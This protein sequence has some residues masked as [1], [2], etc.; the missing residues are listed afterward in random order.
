MADTR[1]LAQLGASTSDTSRL[2]ARGVRTASDLMRSDLLDVAD[3]LR[4]SV[5]GASRALCRV[6]KAVA[7]SATDVA[8]M[9]RM[10]ASGHLP[11][12]I[13]PLDAAMRGGLPPRAITELA[14]PAGAG[15][16]QMCFAL[17]LSAA[18][19]TTY[20]GKERRA[21]YVDAE[22][23]FSAK[24]VAEMARAWTG[25]AMQDSDVQGTLARIRVVPPPEKVEDMAPLLLGLEQMMIQDRVAVVAVDSVAVLMR[26]DASRRFDL[27]GAQASALRHLAESFN[28]PVVVTNQVVGGGA[29]AGSHQPFG[30][31]ASEGGEAEVAAALGVRWAHAVHTRLTLSRTSTDRRLSVAKSPSM[32]PL[33]F[34]FAITASGLVPLTAGGEVPTL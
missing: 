14:G 11:T 23:K 22:R 27:L 9:R 8:S 30:A 31:I 26:G 28:I 24:R 18:M 25:H 13:S 16:T 3:A 6:A 34:S 32:P 5:Q 10:D 12:K 2:A 15:K 33:S 4:V 29:S 21:V 20:G 1:S 7:P 17:L 19:P